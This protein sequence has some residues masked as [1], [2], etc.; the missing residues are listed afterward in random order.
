MGGT[1]AFMAFIAFS[2]IPTQWA[3]ECGDSMA[4]IQDGSM[5]SW[6]NLQC[7]MQGFHA[8]A[9]HSN[10]VCPRTMGIIVCACRFSSQS[11]SF[12]STI[13]N[14]LNKESLPHCIQCNATISGR[15]CPKTKTTTTT[16]TTTTGAGVANLA[17]EKYAPLFALFSLTSLGVS[18]HASSRIFCRQQRTAT[19]VDAA[20]ATAS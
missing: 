5:M 16:T 13:A 4:Y 18:Q 17:K 10:L 7:N 19:V 2:L 11:L 20:V 6:C 9:G 3:A 8:T 14:C 12:S 15:T 1:R